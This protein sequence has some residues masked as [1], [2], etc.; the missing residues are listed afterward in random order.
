[1]E[2]LLQN[3]EKLITDEKERAIYL[4]RLRYRRFNSMCATISSHLD[5]VGFGDCLVISRYYSKNM[6]LRAQPE[7]GDIYDRLLEEIR[8]AL[9]EEQIKRYGH[10]FEELR[11]I[12]ENADELIDL[13][14][15]EVDRDGQ[16]KERDITQQEDPALFLKIGRAH[17]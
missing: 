9:R 7:H 14:V 11:V 4:K 17:V 8:T 10:T 6:R 1:M 16:L 13:K 3:V 15:V 12:A 2:T 5:E